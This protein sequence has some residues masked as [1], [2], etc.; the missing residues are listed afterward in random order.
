MANWANWKKVLTATTLACGVLTIVAVQAQQKKV[1]SLGHLTPRDY[2]EI[3]QLVAHYPY[4]LDRGTDHG[5][6]YAALFTT[7]GVFQGNGE[8]LRGRDELAKMADKGEDAPQNVGHFM[9]NHVI[10]P[11]PN[12]VAV[13]KQYLLTISAF[14][15][16]ENGRRAASIRQWHYEDVYEK[17]SEGWLFKSRTLIEKPK[18][19]SPAPPVTP[20]R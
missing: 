16:E 11:G 15:P 3:Q 2:I 8:N 14:G 6:V 1:W 9:M 7:D 19:R 10:E 13:G 4:A 20:S 17:T 5:R 12:G 18:G